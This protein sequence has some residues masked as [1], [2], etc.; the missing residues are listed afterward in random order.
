MR[1]RFQARDA[2]RYAD[3]NIR[4][5]LCFVRG[6]PS[7]RINRTGDHPEPVR[8][9]KSRRGQHAPWQEN[10]RIAPGRRT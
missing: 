2:A 9:T 3:V 7:A 6:R 8:R 1:G 10:P 4:A 5:V